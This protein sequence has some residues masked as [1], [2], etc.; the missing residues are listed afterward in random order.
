MD[1]LTYM[2]YIDA[3]MVTGWDMPYFFYN[4]TAAGMYN[5]SVKVN[6]GDMDS[7]TLWFWANITEAVAPP[8]TWNET[9]AA[10]E[11]TDP[12][13]DVVMAKLTLESILSGDFGSGKKGDKPGVDIVKLSSVLDGENIKVTMEL[14]G[15]PIVTEELLENAVYKVFFV[16]DGYVEP[17]FDLAA[18]DLYYE[19]ESDEYYEVGGWEGWG[20]LDMG[21]SDIGDPQVSGNMIVWT[22]SLEEL[23][24]AG[25][26]PE[27][28]QL[29][30]QATYMKTGTDLSMESYYDSAAFGAAQHITPSAGD[31]DDDD[32]DGGGGLI[33]IIIVI[34]VVLLIIIIIVVVFMM[35]G[36]KGGEELPETPSIGEEMPAEGEMPVEGGE[37]PVEGMEQPPMEGMEQPPM[38]GMEQPPMEQPMPEETMEQPMMP[39]QP[40]PPMPPQQPMAPPQPVPPQ[41]PP[42][43]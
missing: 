17:K 41:Q 21:E 35:K 15:A 38:E 29:F 26:T 33:I 6:D 12:S 1:E 31:D 5:V 25:V 37:M 24:D 40:V 22:I 42:Q 8:P 32:D 14:A 4:W 13:G 16:K 19:P 9:N 18:P 3:T 43:Q 30:G 2:W 39:E 20:Y 23:E 36:K 7:E 34:V 11:N 28:F 10:F 27:D